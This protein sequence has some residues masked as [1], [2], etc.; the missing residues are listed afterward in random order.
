MADLPT[1]R[2]RLAEAEV[3][4]HRLNI[5]QLSASVSVEGK[6]VSY[7]QADREKLAAYIADLKAQIAAAEGTPLRRGPIHL[8]F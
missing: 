5:G 4:Y 6:S 3:A 7:S 1:L 8:G 2:I